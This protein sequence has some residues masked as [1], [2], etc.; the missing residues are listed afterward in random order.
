MT[1][2]ADRK[3]PCADFFREDFFETQGIAL[4]VIHKNKLT[5]TTRTTSGT[6]GARDKFLDAA[7]RSFIHPVLRYFA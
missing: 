3:N 4:Q 7:R 2:T 6:L 5:A 1:E